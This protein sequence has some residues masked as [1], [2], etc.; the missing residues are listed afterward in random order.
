MPT[1]TK[2]IFI[3]ITCASEQES[4]EIARTLLNEKLI[5]CANY[6]PIQSMYWWKNKI[7]ESNEWI[8]I[9]KTTTKN[10]TA[11]QEKVQKIHSYSIPCITIIP[12][13]PN[14]LYANWLN[15]QLNDP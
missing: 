12:V 4:K 9:V 11:I 5:A 1:K 3:Y 2:Y 14:F 8:L 7:Q 15:Q 6:F 13:E 10:S